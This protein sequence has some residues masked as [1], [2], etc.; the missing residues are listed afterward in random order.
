MAGMLS[1]RCKCP[2]SG[3]LEEFSRVAFSLMHNWLWQHSADRAA[4]ISPAPAEAGCD[5]ILAAWFCCGL[6]ACLVLAL[7]CDSL[8]HAHSAL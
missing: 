2:M 6:R 8:L 4:V 5:V 3:Q 1:S 7:A